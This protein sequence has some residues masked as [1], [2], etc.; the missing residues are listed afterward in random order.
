MNV[1]VVDDD[2]LVSVSLKTILEADSEICVVALGKSGQDGINLFEIHKPD[3]MLMDIRMDE[4]T[5]LE[6]GEKILAK[7]PDAKILYLTTFLDDEYIVKALKIG[8]KGYLIKQ[9]FEGIIPAIKAVYSG[10]SV[11]GNEIITKIPGLL[12]TEKNFDFLSCG[13]SE[14][15]LDIVEG[16]A[17]G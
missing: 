12:D 15:D 16:V 1:I 3:I 2:R 4:M 6:A 17:K 13:M 7:N 5:G 9:D 10:Q 8:A 11:F 14:R